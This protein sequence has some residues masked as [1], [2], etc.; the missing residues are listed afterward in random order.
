VDLDPEDQNRS[1]EEI[2]KDRTGKE[3]DLNDFI[4]EDDLQKLYDMLSGD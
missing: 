2:Y 3:L 1:F 4:S